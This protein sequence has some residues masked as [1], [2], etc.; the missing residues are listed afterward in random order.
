MKK[1]PSYAD[2]LSFSYGRPL[3]VLIEEVQKTSRNRHLR[4]AAEQMSEALRTFELANE[5][6]VS[7]SVRTKVAIQEILSK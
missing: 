3:A 2:Q 5:T 4:K 6:G 1:Q 7:K